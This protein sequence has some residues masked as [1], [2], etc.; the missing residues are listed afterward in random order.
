MSD[1]RIRGQFGKVALKILY[2]GEEEMIHAEKANIDIR[3]ETGETIREDASQKSKA[4]PMPEEID[5][6]SLRGIPPRYFRLFDP[7][8][9][10]DI[11]FPYI[12]HGPRR[13]PE[14]YTGN[15]SNAGNVWQHN[16]TYNIAH[17]KIDSISHGQQ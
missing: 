7:N 11:Y 13:T 2:N 8:L 17:S 5:P 15:Q 6:Q 14:P 4:E 9:G 3:K 12:V 1:I 10:Q 16:I